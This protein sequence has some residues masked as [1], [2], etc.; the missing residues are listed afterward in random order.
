MNATR[1]QNYERARQK[2]LRYLFIH[3]FQSKVAKYPWIIEDHCSKILLIHT[4]IQEEPHT[5]SHFFHAVRQQLRTP[6]HNI[7]HPIHPNSIALQVINDFIQFF[8]APLQNIP[9]RF[10]ER[11]PKKFPFY[12]NRL[13]PLNYP[14]YRLDFSPGHANQLPNFGIW[15]WIM[16]QPPIHNSGNTVNVIMSPLN[17]SF[18][19]E[20]KITNHQTLNQNK[21][22]NLVS[23]LIGHRLSQNFKL[24]ENGKF[25]HLTIPSQ[26]SPKS[27]LINGVQF[28]EFLTF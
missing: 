16:L 13:Q 15:H 10:C 8:I 1:L 27:P 25:N 23:N 11:N 22:N 19:F 3:L 5:G 12:M 2:G 20:L 28:M 14:S 7:T 4:H 21:Y 17:P 6:A 26:V 24:L 9:S 18:H